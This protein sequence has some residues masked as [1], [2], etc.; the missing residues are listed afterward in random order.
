M[1]GG[2]SIENT[3]GNRY[4]DFEMY[5]TDI[6]YDRVSRKFYGYGPDAGHTSWEF[7]ASGNITKPGDIIFATEF[8]G[9]SI[10]SLQARIWINKASLSLTPTEFNWTGVFDGATAGSQYGYAQIT[11]KTSGAYYTGIGSLNGTWAGPFQLVKGDNSVVTTY[12]ASQ[13]MEFSVNLSKLGL[14]PVQLLGSDACG[15]PFRRILVKS[16]SSSSFTAELK[17]FVGPFDFFLAPRADVA[18]D[19][20]YYCGTMGVST[21]QVLN[22]VSTSTYTWSTPDG[23]FTGGTSGASTTVNAAGT[24]ILTQRLQS[25]CSVY[26]TDTVTITYDPSCTI[27]ENYLLSFDAKLNNNTSQITWTTANSNDLKYFEIERSVDGKLFQPVGK[28]TAQSA[29]SSEIDYSTAD[30]VAFVS[31][32]TVY[33]RLK[34]FFPGEEYKYSRIV[35]VK[36]PEREAASVIVSPNPARENIRMN[37]FTPDDADVKISV[38]SADGK[39]YRAISTHILKGSSFVNIGGLDKWPENIYHVQILIGKETYTKKIVLVK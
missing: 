10:A 32:P 31:A 4:F 38:Y 30:N 18:A 36:L 33:Y 21:L 6:Y 19:V 22:P 1:F 34:V 20:P 8:G 39:L 29:N 24:Y 25:G 15:M 2:I 16:R 5:Q 37:L 28:I 3:T 26:A 12:T 27:L 17:D 13:F 23:N 11:P 7:D 14:D 35:Q 9:S